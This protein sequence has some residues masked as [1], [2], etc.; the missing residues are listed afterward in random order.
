MHTSLLDQV[1]VC[2]SALPISCCCKLRHSTMPQSGCR[3]GSACRLRLSRPTPWLLQAEAQA[4]ATKQERE[5]RRLQA[6]VEQQ[7]AAA[8]QAQSDKEQTVLDL[9]QALRKL[10]Q[11][12]DLQKVG[13]RGCAEHFWGTVW[14]QG[15]VAGC[16]SVTCSMR[17]YMDGAELHQQAVS[18]AKA[19]GPCLHIMC[20]TSRQS[21]P[22]WC[23]VKA[24]AGAPGAAE[25]AVWACVHCSALLATGSPACAGAPGAAGC[26]AGGCVYSSASLKTSALLPVQ[27]RLEQQAQ[28]EREA[29]AHKQRL[30]VEAL[31]HRLQLAQT[32]EQG[33]AAAA[34]WQAAE[35]Q[36]QQQQRLEAVEVGR[37]DL[38]QPAGDGLLG[39]RCSA[40]GL[41]VSLV[42]HALL[43]V[44]GGG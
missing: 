13:T 42:C 37:C 5:R 14:A 31:E 12:H 26:A 6:E 25:P 24:C 35:L 20:K 27:H 22:R 38:R 17:V 15:H 8:Q 30:Q 4:T 11:E 32:S 33:A 9:R 2:C 21:S 1:K 43:M 39:S 3:R 19:A 28:L 40:G 36:R 10:Q 23:W 18:C 7:Q 16:T 29:A 34:A 41:G 44:V